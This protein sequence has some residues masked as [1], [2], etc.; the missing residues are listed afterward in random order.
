ML[1]VLS[2]SNQE[3]NNTT[4]LEIEPKSGEFPDSIL[5]LMNPG[6][7]LTLKGDG[8][9]L[10]MVLDGTCVPALDGHGAGLGSRADRMLS[11]ACD[12][13][14]YLTKKGLQ[15]SPKAQHR[16]K[17]GTAYRAKRPGMAK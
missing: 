8:P 15:K 4:S 12:R 9:A 10:M 13:G 1:Q 14:T 5:N 11:P 3:V 16:S 7:T 17:A 2:K 6:L